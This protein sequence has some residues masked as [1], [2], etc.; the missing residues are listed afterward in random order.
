MIS[1]WKGVCLPRA[2]NKSQEHARPLEAAGI[3]ER[4]RFGYRVLLRTS[5]FYEV[6]NQNTHDMTL[7]TD[8]AGVGGGIAEL[9]SGGQLIIVL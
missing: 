4:V 1:R 6:A 3:E 8:Q 5:A 9:E 7:L 2:E